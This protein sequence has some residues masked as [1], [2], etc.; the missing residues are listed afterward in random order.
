ARRC[1]PA[2]RAWRWARRNRAIASLGA[3]VAVL[4]AALAVGSTLA[5]IWLNTERNRAL[6]HLWGAYVDRAHAGRSSRQDGQR[7]SSLD[8]L[9]KAAKIRTTGEL[10]NEAIACLALVDLRPVHRFATMAHEDD[11]FAVDPALERYALGDGAGNV[12]VHRIDDGR[13]IL[14]LP[15]GG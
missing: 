13:E 5:A 9:T 14:R 10:R 11:R 15:K 1:S 7:F 2:E 4:V 12:R 3:S 6:D 8:V